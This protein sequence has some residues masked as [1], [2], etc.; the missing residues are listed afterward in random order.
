M[1]TSLRAW[2]E[3]VA[4]LHC[5]RSQTNASHCAHS[6]VESILSDGRSYLCGDSISVADIAFASLAF[7]V[8]LPDETSHIFLPYDPR[9]LPRAY[10][11]IIKRY[12]PNLTTLRVE[13]FGCLVEVVGMQC[14]LVVDGSRVYGHVLLVHVSICIF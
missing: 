7:P 8:L 5:P 10:V 6:L 4:S 1:I 13:L 2:H 11:E 14:G 3:V 12:L 9:T